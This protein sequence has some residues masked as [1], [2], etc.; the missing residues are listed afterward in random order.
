MSKEQLIAG[1]MIIIYS[2]FMAIGL[3]T[4]FSV[5]FG[6]FGEAIASH[7]GS[8]IGLS[9]TFLLLFALVNIVGIFAGF[10][11]IKDSKFAVNLALP[12]SMVSIVNFPVGTLV[13]GFYIWQ[14]L[15]KP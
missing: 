7:P 10:L 13:G 5:M 3:L 6:Q 9:A 15:R 1:W 8:F 4:G 2:V 11:V 14:H 12:F